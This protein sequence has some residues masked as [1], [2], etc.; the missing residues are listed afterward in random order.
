[1]SLVFRENAKNRQNHCSFKVAVIGGNH[2]FDNRKKIFLSFKNQEI[3]LENCNHHFEFM[4][5]GVVGCGG[6]ETY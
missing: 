2:I 4:T 5:R 1:M 3:L 6:G